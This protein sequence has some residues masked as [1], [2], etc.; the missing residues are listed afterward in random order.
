MHRLNRGLIYRGCVDELSADWSLLNVSDD[1]LTERLFGVN[2][3]R[4]DRRCLLNASTDMC[5]LEKPLSQLPGLFPL[6]ENYQVSQ[7]KAQHLE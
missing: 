5:R 1:Q 6:V 3:G 7:S 4:R 2:G